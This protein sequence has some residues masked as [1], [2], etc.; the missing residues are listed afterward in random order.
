MEEP[1]RLHEFSG[2]GHDL[3]TRPPPIAQV[4][5]KIR[6][7][8]VSGSGGLRGSVR[9]TGLVSLLQVGSFHGAGKRCLSAQVMSLKLSWPLKEDCDNPFDI[10][11]AILRLVTA[12][13]KPVL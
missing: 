2:V 12:E 10:S 4:T 1:G 5:Q 9:H 8:P 6:V 7:A 13:R 3:V 11:N